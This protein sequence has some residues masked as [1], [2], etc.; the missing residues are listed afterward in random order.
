MTDPRD[1]HS[2]R[3]Y[4]VG[5]NGWRV[6][7][8]LTIKEA[9]GFKTLDSLPAL[10]RSGNHGAWDENGIL[11]TTRENRWPELYCEHQAA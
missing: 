11:T 6:S 3:R 2:P 10:D 8:G 4:F 5:Q 7:V 9:F 1:D